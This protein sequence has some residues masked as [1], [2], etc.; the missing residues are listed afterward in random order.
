MRK[1]KS[2]SKTSRGAVARKKRVGTRMLCEMLRF[3]HDSNVEIASDTTATVADR[4]D[5]AET[6]EKARQD[7]LSWGCGWAQRV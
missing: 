4:K 3:V 6:A 7:G 5:A 2:R 1:A